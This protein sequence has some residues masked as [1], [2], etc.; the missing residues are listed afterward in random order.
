MQTNNAI[1]RMEFIPGKWKLA[2]VIMLLRL[3]KSPENVTI[4]LSISLLPSFS[5]RL[6]KFLLKRLKL[7]IDDKNIIPEYQF[8]FHNKR[9]TIDRVYNVISKALEEKEYCCGVFLD[10]S[11]TFD[12]GFFL[13]LRDKLPHTWCALLKLL[14]SYSTRY[15]LQVIDEEAITR[16]KDI[17]STGVSQSSI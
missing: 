6:E 14:E 3:G 15:K 10:V 8:G 7:I 5:K 13:K 17:L 4:Y 1:L 11:Q 9:S 16:W 2:Q 12:K